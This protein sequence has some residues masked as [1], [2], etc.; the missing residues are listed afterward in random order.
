MKHIL[1]LTI[2]ILLLTGCRTT[3]ANYRA[4]YDVAKEAREAK[5]AEDDGL[6]AE[7]RAML[8]RQKMRGVSKQ[9]VGSDTLVITSLFVKMTAG[10]PDRVPRYSIAVNSF[11]QRFNAQA[12]MRRLQEHGYPEAYIFET[13]TPDYYVATAGTNALDSIP[14]L[15][16]AADDARQLGAKEGFPRIIQSGGWE[17]K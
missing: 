6:D 7:T 3:E 8:E 15:L 13:G 11:S 14:A 4:A 10:A 2:S 9:I 17:R 12:M 5:A 1:L 16:R